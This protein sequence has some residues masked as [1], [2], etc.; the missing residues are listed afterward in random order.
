MGGIF[1]LW[2]VFSI[3]VA[4][5][6]ILSVTKATP[7]WP[8]LATWIHCLEPAYIEPSFFKVLQANPIYGTTPF[9]AKIAGQTI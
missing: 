9:Y 4:G 1:P 5:I 3:F 8:P 7:A 2:V 6:F